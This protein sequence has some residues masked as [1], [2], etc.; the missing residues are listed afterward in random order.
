MLL[1]RGAAR[2]SLGLWADAETD[3]RGAM[4]AGG[5]SGPAAPSGLGEMAPSVQAQAHQLLGLA[6]ARRGEL[7]GEAQARPPLMKTSRGTPAR[8]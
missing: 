2:Y 7:W 8:V 1:L 5:P 6:L 4:A 3:V